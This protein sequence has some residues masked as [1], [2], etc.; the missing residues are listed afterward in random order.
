MAM[1]KALRRIEKK[2]TAIRLPATALIIPTF[3]LGVY[4]KDNFLGTLY[5]TFSGTL[6]VITKASDEIYKVCEML[7]KVNSYPMLKG[8]TK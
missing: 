5:F 6:T 8:I 3:L 1:L 2:I 4:R 7:K